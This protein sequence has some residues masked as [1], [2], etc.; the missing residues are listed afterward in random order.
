LTT[1]KSDESHKNPILLQYQALFLC[2]PNYTFQYLFLLLN[3]KL[4]IQEIVFQDGNYTLKNI[5]NFIA[6]FLKITEWDQAPILF[7]MNK[8]TGRVMMKLIGGYHCDFTDT[9]LTEIIGFEKKTYAYKGEDYLAERQG[10]ISRGVD[11]LI[12]HCDIVR[13]VKYDD[14]I[15]TG[16][17]YKFSPNNKPFPMILIEKQFP[18]YYDIYQNDGINSIRMYITDQNKIIVDLNKSRGEYECILSPIRNN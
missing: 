10:N 14:D 17:L 5:Y 8:S 3:S 4:Q 13:N 15:K 2:K 16:I 7:G 11:S 9:E 1:L 6:S 12:I 18:K